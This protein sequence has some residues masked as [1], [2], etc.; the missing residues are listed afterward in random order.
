MSIVRKGS[1][2][3]TTHTAQRHQKHQKGNE[4]QNGTK[5]KKKV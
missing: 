1:F 5:Y 2:G 3:A 4:M